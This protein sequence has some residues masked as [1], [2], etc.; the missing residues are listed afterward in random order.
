MIIE[1]VC[2]NEPSSNAEATLNAEFLQ[3]S[4]NISR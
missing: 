3:D 4:N 1:K 2:S